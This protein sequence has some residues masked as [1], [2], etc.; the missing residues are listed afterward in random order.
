[1]P[2][3]RASN[4]ATR[5]ARAGSSTPTTATCEGEP[6]LTKIQVNALGQP[7]PGG[8][9]VSDPPTPGD[10]LKLT[11]D[12]DVQ[13]AGESALASRGLPG[14]FVTMDVKDGQ[15]LG[16]GS[17]PTYDPTVFTEPMTQAQVDAS[18]EIRCWRR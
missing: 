15:L 3:T 18:T 9:L 1:M 11:I 10:N 7:T 2:C 14:A 16:L 4:R 12:P 13:A 8:Q 5:S 6:G 17:F